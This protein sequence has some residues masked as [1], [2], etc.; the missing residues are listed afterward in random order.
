MLLGQRGKQLVLY[1]VQEVSEDSMAFSLQVMFSNKLRLKL[2]P[3]VPSVM[4]AAN[5]HTHDI[6]VSIR[7]VTA[8]GHM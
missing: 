1:N 8:Y 2:E 6:H 3:N 5:G 4:T 7:N